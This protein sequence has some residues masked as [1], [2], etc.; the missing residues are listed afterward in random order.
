MVRSYPALVLALALP[1]GASASGTPPDTQ[2]GAAQVF[3]MC[4]VSEAGLSRNCRFY[5]GTDDPTARRLAGAELGYLD[6]HPAPLPGARPGGEVKVLVRL[7]VGAAPDG[8]GFAIGAPE[9]PAPAGTEIRRP[10]WIASPHGAWT[11]DLTAELARRSEHEGDATARCT[12]TAAG[13]LADCWVEKESPPD[14]GFGEAALVMLQH[15][16]MKP[17]AG[18]GAAVAGRAYVQT[19][20]FRAP[21]DYPTMMPALPSGSMGTPMGMSMPH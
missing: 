15:A 20:H 7:N 14:L 10:A 4:A 13:T 11:D 3:L 5:T 2:P 8:H 16:R 9:V 19:F 21:S 17:V 18:D 1:A 12:A 6:A